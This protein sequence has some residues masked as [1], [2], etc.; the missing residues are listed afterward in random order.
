MLIYLLFVVGL[1]VL[2]FGGEWL[3]KGS[4]GL[5]ERLNISPLIIGLTIVAFGTSAPELVISLQSALSGNPG[6]AV[7][8]I[9][10]SNIANVFLVLGVP[11]MIATI[12]CSSK[13][14]RFTL[15]LLLATTALFCVELVLAPIGR[16]AGLL[17][18]VCLAI[19]LG[20]QFLTARQQNED[21][22][23]LDEV[24]ELPK[25]LGVTIALLLVGLVA[26]PVGASVAVNAAVDIARVW[27][28]S[29]EV[30]GLTI[31]AIGTSLPELATGIM[32]AR[33]G[34]AS[35][36]IGNVIGSNF[37]NIAAIMGITAVVAGNVPVGDH[38][39]SFD[40]G[41]MI[42]ATI[43]LAVVTLAGFAINR[44]AGAVLFGAY[45]IYLVATAML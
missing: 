5:A 27:N 36:G 25:S 29:D 1:V 17:L 34:N 13:D 43:F 39:V 28:V 19:F 15:Y 41:I 14:L 40:M 11:A 42:V 12:Y 31:V 4:V 22:D 8:N 26:L 3:V 18:L 7:G 32:A 45:C 9:V 10:G 2:V 38:I 6:V 37:F 16:I 30:I 35:V 20:K 24:G 44:L 23:Y 21:P 33:Q